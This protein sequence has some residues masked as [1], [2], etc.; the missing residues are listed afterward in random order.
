MTQIDFYVLKLSQWEDRLEFAVRLTE[1]ALTTKVPVSLL[2]E[3]ANQQ[4]HLNDLLWHRTPESFLPHSV[5]PHP[6]DPIRVVTE[7]SN[8]RNSDLIINL[9]SSWPEGFQDYVR[10]AEIV[11]QDEVT[12]Q[13][14]RKLYSQYK[15]LGYSIRMHNITS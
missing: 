7:L 14:T 1:K 13:S 8:H 2:V 4:T 12:L 5:I 10:L 11:I 6:K 9:R 3:D 15:S